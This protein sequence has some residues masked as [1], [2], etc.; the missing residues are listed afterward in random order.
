MLLAVH[1][2]CGCSSEAG[3]RL[4]G[5]SLCGYR[6]VQPGPAGLLNLADL[7]GSW[8]LRPPGA[9]A[10]APMTSQAQAL[11]DLPLRYPALTASLKK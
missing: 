2:G 5:C 3:P 6:A 9:P 7:L 1:T 10:C 11:R 4:V 8:A